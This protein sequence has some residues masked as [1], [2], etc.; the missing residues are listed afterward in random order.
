MNGAQA[1]SI[2]LVTSPKNSGLSVSLP[3]ILTAGKSVSGTTDPG[4]QKAISRALARGVQLTFERPLTPEELEE[5][6]VVPGKS[7]ADQLREAMT[8]APGIT[9]G[10]I[11]GHE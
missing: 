10:A 11:E 3:T 1:R 2:T 9:L 8:S 7:F 5:L 6:G 4:R